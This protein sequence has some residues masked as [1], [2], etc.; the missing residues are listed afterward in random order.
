MMALS[1]SFCIAIIPPII[2]AA[3][4]PETL[5]MRQVDFK[6][7]KEEEKI[8]RAVSRDEGGEGLGGRLLSMLSG[9]HEDRNTSEPAHENYTEL[10][11]VSSSG[12]GSQGS[13]RQLV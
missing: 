6:E 1:I 5:G 11:N 3:F 7:E 12:S 8:Q 2:G 9:D 13:N 10:Q 4:V